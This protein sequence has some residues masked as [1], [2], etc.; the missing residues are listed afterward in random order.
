MKERDKGSVLRRGKEQ[1]IRS[2][3]SAEENDQSRVDI[4]GVTIR[5]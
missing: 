1:E 3:E 5:H 2:L 4:K